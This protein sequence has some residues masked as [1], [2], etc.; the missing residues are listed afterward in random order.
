MRGERRDLETLDG[1]QAATERNRQQ[2]AQ[3]RAYQFTDADRR[4]GH[5]T[6][7]AQ[8]RYGR[9]T[10]GLASSRTPTETER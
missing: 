1:A 7:R 2:R 10:F 6:Q 5:Q 3:G 9:G 8:G 4:K